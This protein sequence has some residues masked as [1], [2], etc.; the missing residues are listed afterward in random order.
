MASLVYTAYPGRTVLYTVH[1]GKRYRAE[2]HLSWMESSFVSNEQLAQKFMQLGFSDVDIV[3]HGQRRFA[4][5]TWA[6]DDYSVPITDEHVYAV[7]ELD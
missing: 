1:K 6:Y 7:A 2:L 4:T 5:G 3:G